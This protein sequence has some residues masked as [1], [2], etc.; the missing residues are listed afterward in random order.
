MDHYQVNETLFEIPDVMIFRYITGFLLEVSD[1]ALSFQSTC[2]TLK[3]IINLGFRDMIEFQD[4]HGSY[5]DY[6]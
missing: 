1:G 5:H 4:F 2:K 6:K 3:N